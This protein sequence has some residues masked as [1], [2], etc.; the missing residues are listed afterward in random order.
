MIGHSQDVAERHYLQ[1]T[2]EDMMAAAKN[3]AQMQFS[4][5]GMNNVP[6]EHLVDFARKMLEREEDRKN[7]IN[8]VNEEKVIGFVRSTVKV[9]E[10]EVSSEK[11][12]KLFEK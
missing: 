2:D 3:I 10:K 1:I 12:N 7:V 4:Q 5:Y 9:D 6:E 8:R 11:F